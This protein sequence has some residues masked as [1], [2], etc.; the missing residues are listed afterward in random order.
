MIESRRIE[1]PGW[2]AS[3]NRDKWEFV[4]SMMM[5]HLSHKGIGNRTEQVDGLKDTFIEN[6][7]YHLG[8]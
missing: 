4:L 3:E 7:L 1:A 5:E 6:Y 8:P 2:E